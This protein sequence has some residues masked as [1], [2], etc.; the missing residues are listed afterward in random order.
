M[1]GLH[2]ANVRITQKH[3]KAGHEKAIVGTPGSRRVYPGRTYAPHS[4]AFNDICADLKREN[5]DARWE[6][7]DKR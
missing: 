1:M 2:F 4:A 7:I 3:D 6:W 5:P